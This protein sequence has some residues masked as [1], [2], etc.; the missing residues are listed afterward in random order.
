MRRARRKNIS[1]VNRRDMCVAIYSSQPANVRAC[2]ACAAA[3]CN[4]TQ[5]RE[6]YSRVFEVI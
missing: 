6:S 1:I 3:G 2:G 5:K 4:L